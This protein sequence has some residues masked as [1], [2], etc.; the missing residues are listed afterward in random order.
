V[1]SS[2][3]SRPAPGTSPSTTAAPSSSV[4]TTTTVPAALVPDDRVLVVVEL[5]G[6][7]D[8]INTLPPTVGTYHDL[9]PS[10]AL[11][12]DMMVAAGLDGH[13]LHPSL[14]PIVPLLDD[15]VLGIVAG[16]GWDAPDRSH[17]ASLDRWNRADRIDE[18]YGWVGRWLDT[19][20]VEP[21]ALGAVGLG[22]TNELMKGSRRGA[23]LIAAAETF[24]FPAGLSNADIRRLTAPVSADPMLAAAQRAFGDAVGAVAEFD[25]VADAVRAAAGDTGDGLTST[26]GPF[27]TGLAVAAE[28]ILSDVDTRVVSVAGSGFDTHAQQLATH[29]DLLADLAAGLVAF[30][31]TLEAAGQADRVLLVTTSEFGRRAAENGSGGCDH[32][33]G[34][35]SFALGRGIVPG[36]HGA[37]DLTDLLDGDLRPVIDPRAVF[38]GCLDWLGG[39][40]E[41]ILGAR[42]DTGFT[43]LA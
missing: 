33:A 13:A 8:A 14:A 19:L 9:R 6:G 37:I 21:S 43:L 18:P 11:P 1:G 39:D 32:G 35:V 31:A 36:L 17:F 42:H 20:D 16:I 3:S 23:T 28:L 4:I 10:L 27:S 24:G 40:V 2:L 34:G 5:T 22:S 12:D 41:R 25:P 15:G 26:G 7:N 29:G 38:T 30:W